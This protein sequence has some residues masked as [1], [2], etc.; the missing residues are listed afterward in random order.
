MPLDI[1]MVVDLQKAKTE[2]KNLKKQEIH[3]IFIKTSQI[4]LVF[5]MIQ[6]MEIL[7]VELKKTVFDKISHDKAINNA[8]K[9]KYDGYGRGLF[10][11]I[12]IY[13]DKRIVGGVNT[14]AQW[15]QNLS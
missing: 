14:F 15:S 4:K 6:L 1:H 3:E 2:Y 10:Q 9:M 13:F 11:W 8:K 5:D 12:T 7:K